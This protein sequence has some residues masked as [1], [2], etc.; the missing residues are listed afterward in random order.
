[1]GLREGLQPAFSGKRLGNL[2]ISHIGI[3]K[4][5]LSVQDD[6]ASGDGSIGVALS[7]TLF[8]WCGESYPF[9]L[10]GPCQA[11]LDFVRRNTV[12]R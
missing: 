1:M 10:I 3:Y 5:A 12:K 8:H 4:E 2:F 6:A 7:I 9:T 11:G